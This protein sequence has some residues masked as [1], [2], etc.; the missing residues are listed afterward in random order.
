M[1]RLD[2]AVDHAGF[3][4]PDLDEAVEFFCAA[5]GCELVLRAGPYDSV[6]YIWPGEPEAEPA[7]LRLALLRHGAHNLELLEYR[8]CAAQLSAP[9]R[10]S[11]PGSGHIAFYVDDV[12]AALEELG[13]LPGVR[14]LGP[15]IT[16]QEGPLTGLDWVYVLTPWGMLVE[17]I[18]WPLGMPYERTTS[19]RLAA[20][21]MLVRQKARGARGSGADIE[22]GFG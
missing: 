21:P 5:F 2:W 22:A 3:T 13:A 20:P 17:L 6:G 19:S 4:V 18:R 14:I 15:V 9:P 7:T 12:S 8:G 16:E 10:P 11:E 1:T